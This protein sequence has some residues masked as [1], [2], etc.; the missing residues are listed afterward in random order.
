ML[1]P[2]RKNCFVWQRTWYGSESGSCRWQTLVN[3][4]SSCSSYMMGMS[5][6]SRTEWSLACF[7]ICLRG[8]TPHPEERR[9]HEKR[10]GAC[11]DWL[12]YGFRVHQTP[13]LPLC[14]KSAMPS[15]RNFFKDSESHT[16]LQWVELPPLEHLLLCGNWCFYPQRLVNE[17]PWHQEHNQAREVV[18]LSTFQGQKISRKCFW[19]GGTYVCW[20]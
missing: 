14:K 19:Y 15:T 18:Q 6:Y 20:L 4:R 17:A 16:A 12:S 9:Q 7:M 10:P 8:W 13:L 2:L 11:S 1:L 5:G 3:I